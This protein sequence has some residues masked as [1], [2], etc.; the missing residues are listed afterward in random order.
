MRRLFSLGVA[1]ATAVALGAPV[2]QAAPAHAD[3]PTTTVVLTFD[4][5]LKTGVS[6][7]APALAAHGMNGTFY[8]NSNV[9]GSDDGHLSWA[10]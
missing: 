6:D 1:L 7:A 3:A 5:T 4:G 9:V 8:V 2:L 10:T